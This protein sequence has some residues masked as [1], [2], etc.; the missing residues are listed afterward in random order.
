MTE[1]SFDAL[2]RR[3]ACCRQGAPDAR[4]DAR[5]ARS[6]REAMY[7]L[8]RNRF[9]AGLSMLGIS[10]GI[11]SVVMLLSYGNGFHGALTPGLRERV[12]F[13]RRDSVARADEHAGGRRARRQAR[14]ADNRRRTCGRGAAAGAVRE[15]GARAEHDRGV[16]DQAV[17]LPGARRVARIRRHALG[18]PGAGAGTVP[19]GRGHAAAPARGVHR[20]RGE[21]QAVRA[22][23][24]GRPDDPAQRHVVRSDRRD[25]R[26]GAALELLPARQGEHLHPLHRRESA[27]VP[28][29]AERARLA[30]GRS[31]DGR[32]G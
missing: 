5:S 6:A 9:R 10:W 30:V 20:V 21:P 4:A 15:P 16:R 25:E 2:V 17:Q 11:V 19:V 12:R 26:Q 22:G 8:A 31:D 13:G 3:P 14:A 18:I 7:G 23:E 29:V 32:E 24:R 28:A 27:L 1:I